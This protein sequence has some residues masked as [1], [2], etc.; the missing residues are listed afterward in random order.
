MF[1][2]WLST[3]F[4][5]AYLIANDPAFDPR[6]LVV[7]SLPYAILSG[8]SA[9][10]YLGIVLIGQRL[11]AAATGEETLFFNVIAALAVALATAAS[12]SRDWRLALIAHFRLHLAAA[13]WLTV[14]VTAMADLP[15]GPKLALLLAAFGAA[16]V[17]LG[18]M[19][20]RTPRDSATTPSAS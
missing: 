14:L 16:V 12:Y 1:F 15:A 8:V 10:I 5:I 19:T 20:L 7:R 6:R 18:E 13:A 4:L 17:N 2:A 9:A 3:P 11:F